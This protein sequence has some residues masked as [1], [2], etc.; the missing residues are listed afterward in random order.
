MQSNVTR[1]RPR[2]E[3]I[4]FLFVAC[5]LSFAVFI[6][7]I[8]FLSPPPSKPKHR[9]PQ[10]TPKNLA[11]SEQEQNVTPRAQGGDRTPSA[12][13]RPCDRAQAFPTNK[14][15]AELANPQHQK[16]IR[17]SQRVLYRLQS[18]SSSM[19]LPKALGML[20]RM[21]PY[22]FEEL[23][24]TCCFERGWAIERNFHYTN[25]GGI[26]GRVTIAGKTYVIQA[27]RYRGYINP[28]HILS[29]LS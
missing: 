12:K 15:E 17:E 22:A 20:R 10:Q 25:D 2:M 1:D 13:E 3:V 23:L 19:R 27:K 7:A 6:C 9:P 8:A 21:S 18:E 5:F 16:Y 11:S 29:L 26:D 14:L 28:K 4:V 24:L